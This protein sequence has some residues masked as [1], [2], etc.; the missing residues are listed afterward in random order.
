MNIIIIVYDE[1]IVLHLLPTP[2]AQCFPPPDV[3]F[4]IRDLGQ[5]FQIGHEVIFTCESSKRRFNFPPPND[6]I[7]YRI[8]CTEMLEFEPP[9]PANLACI[10]EL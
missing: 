2:E 8:V 3:P 7:F 6:A 1:F 4:A 9:L 5:R 10:R